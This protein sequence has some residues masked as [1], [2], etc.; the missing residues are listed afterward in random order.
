M[1]L[2]HRLRQHVAH[3]HL[4]PLGVELDA[5]IL[6]HRD[7]AAERVLPD[8]ALGLHVAVEAA[9]FGDRC[10]LAGAHLDAAIGDKIECRDT[11]GDALRW[12][13]G[14]LHDAVAKPDV[15]G[16]LRRRTEEHFGSR[17]VRVLFEE[18]MLDLPG[19][20]VAK[21]VGQL[22][23]VERI[24]VEL[25]FI[26]RPPGARQL[27]LVEDAEFH[28][29]SLD[30][31]PSIPPEPARSVKAACR[32]LTPPASAPPRATAAAPPLSDGYALP[33]AAPCT[34][35]R[36]T[37]GRECSGWPRRP[38]S[39]VL[40]PRGSCG[41]RHPRRASSAPRSRPSR[42]PVPR[43]PWPCWR[44]ARCGRIA[45][46]QF[47]SCPHGRVVDRYRAHRRRSG[48]SPSGSRHPADW[49]RRS[50]SRCRTYG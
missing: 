50:R 3:R 14:E 25:A 35:R 34:T 46:P 47:R 2:L 4:L 31:L 19:V 13:G 27:Q 26:V 42:S 24:L 1:G 28:G 22:H 7:N 40:P 39:Q 44:P 29:T 10:R 48:R 38:P 37:S 17:R 18:M 21:P 36:H 12:I 23:L 11:F 9:E 20:V 43:P 6:E 49:Q 15:L 41:C 33:V 8:L 45:A 30:L 32:R 16:P 5:L